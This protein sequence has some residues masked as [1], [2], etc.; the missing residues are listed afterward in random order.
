MRFTVA[1]KIGVFFALVLSIGLSA[2]AFIYR[3]LG[4]VTTKFE[5]LAEHRS[6]PY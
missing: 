6:T 2:I 1:T 4:M 5:E 3:G